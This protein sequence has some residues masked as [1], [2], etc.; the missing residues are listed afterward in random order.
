V[1]WRLADWNPDLIASSD[2]GSNQTLVRAP[3][4]IVEVRHLQLA[5]RP[6]RRRMV[7][8]RLELPSGIV[9]VANLHASAGLPAAAGAE[10]ELAAERAVDWAAG[11][12]LVLGGDLNLRPARTPAPFAAVRER[13][14]LGEPTSPSAID[15]LL[16]RGLHVE[17]PPRRLPAEEREVIEPGGLRI[18]LSDHAPVVARFRMP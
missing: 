13:F 1:Q 3:G 17:E 16:V 12:P 14:A 5:R 6:E 8:T 10:L 7:W 18:R 11:D 15:H 2:G 4:R 9:C